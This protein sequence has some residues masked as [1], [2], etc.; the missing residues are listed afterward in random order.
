MIGSQKI[1]DVVRRIRS[2]AII[3]REILKTSWKHDSKTLDIEI[4]ARGAKIT[5]ILTR[6]Y[7]YLNVAYPKRE[8]FIPGHVADELH[9][10]FDTLKAEKVEELAKLL[11]DEFVGKAILD[12]IV[13]GD[14]IDF[15]AQSD[16]LISEIMTVSPENRKFIDR[17]L[18]LDRHIGLQG[19]IT[20]WGRGGPYEDA[21]E[22]TLS[23]RAHYGF[24]R[25]YWVG[26]NLAF[27]KNLDTAI[28]WMKSIT[29]MFLDM[30]KEQRKIKR[31]TQKH[32]KE[33]AT[34]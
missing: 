15:V 23:F 1:Y 3:N 32:A 7:Y 14:K 29:K 8:I 25:F 5:D 9:R 33:G 34:V 2:D 13:N 31:G 30:A 22:G 28:R 16:A 27:L 6:Y 18:C 20:L 17:Y 21:K 19:Q 12:A 24:L 4:G 10:Q 26:S 11:P